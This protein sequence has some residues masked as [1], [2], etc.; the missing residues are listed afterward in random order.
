MVRVDMSLPRAAISKRQRRRRRSAGRRLARMRRQQ[1][2]E[3]AAAEEARQ[4]RRA[5]VAK[6]RAEE[7]RL[8]HERDAAKRGT[9]NSDGDDG[10][11]DV[12]TPVKRRQ[13]VTFADDVLVTEIPAAAGDTLP[14][15]VSSPIGVAVSESAIAKQRLG[16]M[17]TGVGNR[18]V[19]KRGRFITFAEE[20]SDS[21]DDDDDDPEFVPSLDSDGD[22]VLPA[23]RVARRIR[24][25]RVPGGPGSSDEDQNSED[26][27]GGKSKK[28]KTNAKRRKPNVQPGEASPNG[29]K[30]QA[31]K[32]ND[33]R[34][35]PAS[36]ASEDGIEKASPQ[37]SRKKKRKHFHGEGSPTKTSQGKDPEVTPERPANGHASSPL[38][39]RDGDEDEIDSLFGDLVKHRA[40]KK[41]R[42]AWQAAKEQQAGGSP[43]PVRNGKTKKH[44][45]SPARYTEDGLRIVTYDD[46]AA[47]QPKG[48]NGA[49]PFDCSCCF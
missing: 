49:C 4:A 10:K 48:L 5:A 25:M 9:G 40:A 43:K 8:Q 13:S 35:A 29:D 36:P 37:S 27:P 26:S 12:K 14:R 24:P 2:K 15:P 22:A 41:A 16:E 47:D 30:P 17:M 18:R 19:P 44:R 23:P 39:S 6:W 31:P 11:D 32:K 38:A 20:W 3:L 21:S 45:D 34:Q 46:M 33:G 7:A 28:R 1:Q 42:I